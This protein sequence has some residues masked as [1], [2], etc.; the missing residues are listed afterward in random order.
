M[1]INEDTILAL[2]PEISDIN[3]K[4]LRKKVVRIW[5][6][7]CEDGDVKELQKII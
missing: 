4:D 1:R 7:G 2:L 6:E 3:D 5:Q